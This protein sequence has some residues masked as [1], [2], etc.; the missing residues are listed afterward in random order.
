MKFSKKLLNQCL[1]FVK[2]N[3]SEWRMLD[4]DS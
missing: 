1:E 4:A 3:L 2:S